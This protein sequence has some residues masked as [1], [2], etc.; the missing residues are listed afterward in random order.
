VHDN[1]DYSRCKVGGD[2]PARHRP[3]K[4]QLVAVKVLFQMWHEVCEIMR[5]A[6][7]GTWVG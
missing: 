7:S 3:D 2:T 4:K 1:L 6:K 5:G